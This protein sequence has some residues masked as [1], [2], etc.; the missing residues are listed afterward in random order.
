MAKKKRRNRR[1]LRRRRMRRILIVCLAL[2]VILLAAFFMTTAVIGGKTYSRSLQAIDLR[3]RGLTS[4][5]GVARLGNLREALLSGNDLKDVSPLRSL[6]RC[7]YIDLTDNPVSDESYAKLRAALPGCLIL[8]EAKDETTRE[9]ALGGHPLP[10]ADALARV[11]ESHEALTLVDLRGAELTAE[12]TDAL[13]ERFPRIGF[14]SEGASLSFSVASPEDAADTLARVPESTHVI[15]TGYAFAPE[16]YGALAAR[17]PG[18]SLDANISLDGQSV[19]TGATEISL[20][21]RS[22]DDALADELRLFPA[23]EKLTL[24]ESRPTAAARLKESLGLSEIGFRFNGELFDARTID[25]DMRGVPDFDADELAALLSTQPQI[26]TVRLDTP[27]E[28]MMN[29]VNAYKDRVRFDF[30]VTA[31]G[32]TYSTADTFI[33]FDTMPLEDS[34]VDELMSLIA[35][36]PGLKAV[37]MYDSTLSKESMDRLFDGNPDVFFGWTIK[38]CKKYIIRTDITAF[39]T[40]LGSPQHTYTQKDFWPLRYCKNI[41]ALDLGHNAITDASFLTNFPHLKFLIIAD[42]ALTDITPLAELKELEYF[43]LFM[44]YDLKDYTPLSGLP[45]KDLNVRCPEGT[46]NKF[47]ADAFIPIKTLERFWATKALFPKAEE[48]RLREALPDCEISITDSHSTGDGW[49]ENGYY[50]TILRMFDNSRYEELP[51]Q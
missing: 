48:E 19:S 10:D 1:A 38:M 16:E 4:A 32:K 11:F 43:E 50:P 45:L 28:V 7:E 24:G 35:R 20:S 29:V 30:N 3:D 33:D 51:R 42:N 5:R 49:R 6:K 39:S 2:A 34:D 21:G 14:I 46:R 12:E 47:T 13:R 36:M 31:F 44:N 40:Q 8:C 15:L 17:F 37:Y 22:A 23:L 27:D 41:Q 18:L 9:M 26:K 25:A